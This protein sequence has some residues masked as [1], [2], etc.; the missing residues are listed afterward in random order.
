MAIRVS[1]IRIKTDFLF[2]LVSVFFWVANI[3]GSSDITGWQIHTPLISEILNTGFPNSQGY[4]AVDW[5]IVLLSG[6]LIFRYQKWYSLKN[7][8]FPIFAIT[9]IAILFILTNPNNTNDI[10]RIFFS[11]QSRCVIL[12]PLLFYAIIFLNK[13]IFSLF[14]NRFL[15]IGFIVILIKAIIS[16]VYYI[17]GNGMVF[18]NVKATI[19]QADVLYYMS[20]FQLFF[21]LIYLNRGVRKYLYYSIFLLI[22]ILLSY[23]RTETIHSII[24]TIIISV[25]YILKKKS[26]ITSIKLFIGPVFL[27]VALLSFLSAFNMFNVNKIILRQ[28]SVLSF[29]DSKY[30]VAEIQDSGHIKQTVTTF[31]TFINSKLKF[32]GSGI[33]NKAY[34]I[35]GQS[36]SIHNSYVFAYAKHGIM[37][38]FYQSILILLFFSIL[39]KSLFK[40]FNSVDQELIFFRFLTALLLLFFFINGA[41]GGNYLFG[42]DTQVYIIFILLFSLLKIDK[43]NIDYLLPKR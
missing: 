2:Y 18:L 32:W 13:Q 17:T 34:Y 37:L 30:D 21:M 36:K 4:R 24:I 33:K 23:R 20:I 22:V 10:I 28:I 15:Q 39:I 1:K 5:S 11:S 12:F 14:M 38:V 26:L 25:Y 16:F 27:F 41:F 42:R 8:Y 19:L 9:I 35:K 31:D 6:F 3:Y 43:R 29:F 7:K 40:K